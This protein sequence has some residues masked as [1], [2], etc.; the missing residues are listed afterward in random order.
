MGFKQE[1]LEK[2]AALFFKLLAEQII[3]ISDPLAEAYSKNSEIHNIVHTMAAEAGL[4]VFSTPKNVHLVSRAR[5]S[6]FANSYTQMKAKYPGLTR[7]R[8]FYLA[9]II[10]SIFLAEIDKENHIRIRWEEEG[11]SYYHLADLVTATLKS[12]LKRQSEEDCFSENWALAVEEVGE[13]WLTEFSPYRLNKDDKIE[14]T[15]TK[16]NQLSFIN[17]ALK[18]LVKQGLIIDQKDELKLIP[19]PELYE[20]LDDLY[21]KQERYKKFQKLIRESREELEEEK[22]NA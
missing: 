4:R 6:N 13:L 22:K 7:K 10:I 17:T 16:N 12:W 3:S 11:V 19:K 1:D 14:V 9:N 2:G 18:P 20:R 8:K 15:R 21:H 5:D